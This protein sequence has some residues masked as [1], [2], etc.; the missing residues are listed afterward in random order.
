PP[1]PWGRSDPRPG[2]LS[3]LCERW[4]SKRMATSAPPRPTPSNKSRAS[5]E[6]ASGVPPPSDL[7]GTNDGAAAAGQGCDSRRNELCSAGT[8]IGTIPRIPP[9]CPCFLRLMSYTPDLYFLLVGNGPS[10]SRSFQ[11]AERCWRDQ[12]GV[13]GILSFL[14][15][16]RE[17]T[18]TSQQGEAAAHRRPKLFEEKEFQRRRRHRPRPALIERPLPA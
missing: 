18:L 5:G 17:R 4:R 11:R 1:T 9:F 15:F 2:R 8:R 13:A 12:Q 16:G 14:G 7:L 6:P 10:F 3:P